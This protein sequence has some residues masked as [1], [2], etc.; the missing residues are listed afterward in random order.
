MQA[1]PG[2]SALHPV[3]PTSAPPLPFLTEGGETGALMR[4]K[5][6]S[7]T[8]LGPAERWPQSLRTSVSICLGSQ[9]PMVL[10]WGP[11]LTILYNDPYIPALGL[12]H[13]DRA[14][15]CPGA[16]CWY[17][18]WDIVGPMLEQVI[19][20][21]RATWSADLLLLLE[22]SGYSE[23]C[24]F[25]FSYSPIRDESGAVGGVFTPVWETTDKVIGERRLRLLRDLAARA[26][27]A[28]L[29]SADAALR[30]AAEVFASNPQDLPFVLLYRT[31]A[32]GPSRL[33]AW[34]GFTDTP[35]D[36][37]PDIW[38]ID[39]A[40]A[41]AGPVVVHDIP[42][43]LPGGPW[44]VSPCEAV[45]L[46]VAGTSGASTVMIVGV[47]P[48]KR[49]DD[50][51]R[52]FLGLLADGVARAVA[53]AEAYEHERRRAEAL[54]EIDRAKT[55]F[56]SNVSHEFRTPLTLMLGPL[57]DALA[58][59]GNALPID[60]RNRIE[61][62]H[63]NALRLLR[64]VNSLLDFARLE[65]GRA[66][67]DFRPTELAAL[68]ADLAASFR[69]TMERGGLR[70]EVDCTPLDEP[71][72]IDREMWEKIVLNLL[73]NAFKFTFGGEVRVV[74]RRAGEMAELTVR[75]T[76]IG[77]PAHELPRLFDRFHRVEGTHGRSFEGSGI[78]LALVQGMLRLHGGGIRAD[79][80]IGKGT[81]FTATVPFGIFHVP[82]GHAPPDGDRSA[83]TDTGCRAE[84]FVEEAL[85]WL[86]D[87]E[88]GGPEIG[89]DLHLT[90]H[91]PGAPLRADGGPSR[92]VLA[93]DNA[94]MRAYGRRLLVARGYAVTAVADGAAALAACRAVPPDLVLSDVMMPELDGFGLLRA[95]RAEPALR[96]VPVILLSAR[97]GAEATAEGL[98]AGADD[99][100][101][102]PFSA[103]ELLSR[104]SAN[105]VMA[106][107]RRESAEALRART[108]EL[109]TLIETVPVAV[110]FTHDKEARRT[111]GNRTAAQVLR[112]DAAANPSLTA[113]LGEWPE[114]FRALREGTEVPAD[115]LPLQ[116][117]AR[118]EE[119]GNEELEIVSTTAAAGF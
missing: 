106:R 28:A 88:P 50:A 33:V 58:D 26:Q 84:A 86:P 56:F 77:I 7:A 31:V 17:Q 21:G 23:E 109:E 51:Y 90:Q 113:P 27:G 15:G 18:I 38:P 47:N 20:T 68:T 103:R 99:Y 104:V 1:R 22:R 42:D 69:S 112:M 118:G 78:G 64:L 87:A 9:F 110:W 100:L 96:D 35:G 91:T 34:S 54:A 39:A 97:A 70:L 102:K 107:V 52:A 117:A 13:P 6:W 24:Y 63:R 73:S 29:G 114:H 2:E 59:G 48:R 53:E 30:A 61:I 11:D 16:E 55:Q 40:L 79:S 25:T 116:R 5:D 76:G 81:V 74:L 65:A 94:D 93:D 89:A 101:V 37:A 98:D 44:G 95:L 83:R 85:R 71:V 36:I 46:P 62:A 111:S 105:I 32:S 19:R 4:A 80:E 10:W 43:R 67:A 8:P 57:E 75:D 45:A 72:Y 49:L 60:Q 92:I 115:Q 119:V 14:L 41:N 108:A 3:T 66:R 12:K 82:A